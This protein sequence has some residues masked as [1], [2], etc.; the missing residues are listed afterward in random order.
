MVKQKNLFNK[1]LY[2]K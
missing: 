1:L 2:D